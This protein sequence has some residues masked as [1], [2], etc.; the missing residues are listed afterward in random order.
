[1][2]VS[3]GKQAQQQSPAQRLGRAL[4]EIRKVQNLMEL[5]MPQQG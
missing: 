2:R 1:M 3:E 4:T 5:N